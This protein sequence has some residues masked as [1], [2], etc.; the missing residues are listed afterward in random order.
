MFG[1]ICDIISSKS[2]Q[3]F[4][5]YGMQCPFSQSHPIRD[6]WIEIAVEKQKP[7]TPRRRI[8]YGMRGLKLIGLMTVAMAAARRIPY[9]MRGLK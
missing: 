2:G 9:G 4:P 8:P 1:N 7:I 6:A 3:K 5:Y